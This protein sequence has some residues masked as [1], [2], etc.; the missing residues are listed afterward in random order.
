MKL[1][2]VLVFLPLVLAIH[3]TA[4]A[5][6]TV[7]YDIEIERADRE[8]EVH[9][10]ADGPIKDYGK[11]QLKKNVAANRPERMYLDIKNVSFAGPIPG[12]Q[13]GTALARVRTGKRSDGI[14][15]VFDSN[16]DELFDYTIR[17][18]PDGLLVT[19]R[20]PAADLMQGEAS[21]TEP[22]KDIALVLETIYPQPKAEGDLKLVIVT[23]DSPDHALE[24]LKAPPD[25]KIGLKLLKTAK[26][27][28]EISIS[29]M[30]T[31]LTQDL[32]GN[33]S[34]ETSFTL[35]DP[36]GNPK[37]NHRHYA[38][39]TVKAPAHPAFILAEPELALVPDSSDPIGDYR[40]I[41]MVED[42]TNN[43]IY[44]T[45]KKITLTR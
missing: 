15:V 1:T 35:L 22:A 11:F 33:F 27:D 21:G 37:E 28:Q 40:I 34:Y 14:R 39:A 41:G 4:R 6:A 18:Q 43:K 24:W 42:L 36:S 3:A 45:S 12:Q 32:D 8:T 2:R 30:V 19:I 5:D 25:N 29:F 38:K 16:L 23:S 13:V 20:E 26:T 10:K 31:G 44:R 17:E 7:L 9:L